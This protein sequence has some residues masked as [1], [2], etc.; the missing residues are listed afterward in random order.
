MGGGG[1]GGAQ[2]I[3]TLTPAQ[4]RLAQP[5]SRFLRSQIGKGLPTYP[6]ELYAPP[7]EATQSLLEGVLGAGANVLAPTMVGQISPVASALR[8]AL[9]GVPTAGWSPAETES[10]IA[11][12]LR[13]PA[14]RTWSEEV[15][16][17][18]KSAYRGPGTY[19]GG[20]RAKAV[21]R[22]R[23]AFEEGLAAREEEA[24]RYGKVQNIALAEAARQ[25]Q[26][27]AV[28]TAAALLGQGAAAGEALRAYEQARI[29]TAYREWVR[30][31]PG[32]NPA[33]QQILAFLGT[34]MMGVAVSPEGGASLGGM[35][36]AGL[37]GA[38]SGAAIGTALGGP[39]IGTAIGAGAGLLAGGLGS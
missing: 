3:S 37:G 19:W 28:P 39:V 12:A 18:I 25:R 16:P 20:A 6:G 29:D 2:A 9:S 11:K 8:S 34:P 7:S 30:T 35:V 17:E 38:A 4:L 23:E 31:L 22:A 26:A 14:E 13:A 27:G 15:L 1:N 5:L 32:L 21:S 33:I 36:G 10:Y 24:R